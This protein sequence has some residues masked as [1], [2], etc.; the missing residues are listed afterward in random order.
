MLSPQQGLRFRMGEKVGG[1]RKK[2]KKKK[3]NNKQNLQQSKKKKERK[4]GCAEWSE[5]VSEVVARGFSEGRG[6]RISQVKVVFSWEGLV[7]LKEDGYCG[8]KYIRA[9]DIPQWLSQDSSQCL[10]LQ[11]FLL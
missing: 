1:N 3:K 2:K 6:S 5:Q 9:P 11:T 10:P 4:K 7:L 8:A